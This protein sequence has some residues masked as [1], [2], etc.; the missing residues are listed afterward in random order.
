MTYP[1][2]FEAFD[3]HRMLADYP[4]GDAFVARYADMSRDELRGVQEERFARLMARGWQVPFYR[5]LWRGRG[6]EPGDIRGLDDLTK[7]PVYDKSDLMA[8]VAAHPPY[9]DFAGLG[10]PATRA[11]TLWVARV[12][13][14][15]D[16]P[17]LAIQLV[18]YYA[19]F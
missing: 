17:V 13:D 4:V 1:T 3:A 10:D 5:R 18:R 12:L 9:G 6:I 2:Y 8:S 14:R 16:G 7:L 11:P 15:D 19:L